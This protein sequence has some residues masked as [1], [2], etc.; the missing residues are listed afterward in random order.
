MP[1]DIATG[2]YLLG[3]NWSLEGYDSRA[4]GPVRAETCIGQVVL[5]WKQG[6]PSGDDLDHGRFDI[7]D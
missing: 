5:R 3:E 6:P 2:Y 7:I 4:V 1:Y